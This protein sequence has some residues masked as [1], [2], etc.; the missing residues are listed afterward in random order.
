MFN[1]QPLI[2]VG[3]V[4]KK[5]PY[6]LLNTVIYTL[7]DITVRI[8]KGFRYDGCSIPRIFWTLIGSP[9][10]VEYMRASLLHDYCCRHK[11]KF[12]NRQATKV[13][14]EELIN[15]YVPVWKA[16]LMAFL[17]YLWQELPI[18]KGWKNESN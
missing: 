2:L 1:K 17:T 4:N 8:G 7:D 9:A 3:F 13:F 10:D 16:N 11:S 18:N 5:Y 6:L 15:S 12:T 14:K